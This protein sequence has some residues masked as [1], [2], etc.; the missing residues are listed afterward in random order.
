MHKA[1]VLQPGFGDHSIQLVVP[2][3]GHNWHPLQPGLTA[4]DVQ[5]AFV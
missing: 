4:A 3:I 5:A 1:R 2:Q